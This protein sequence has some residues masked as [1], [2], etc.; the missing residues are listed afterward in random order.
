MCIVITKNGK[1]VDA[2]YKP[3]QE[4]YIEL[5]QDSLVAKAFI[6]QEAKA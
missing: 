5:E 1:P 2:F 4:G 6:Y 3:N